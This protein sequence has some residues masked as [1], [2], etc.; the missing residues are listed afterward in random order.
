MPLSLAHAGAGRLGRSPAE[1]PQPAGAQGPDRVTHPA[2]H[3]EPAAEN[4]NSHF[5][6]F[7]Q[8]LC[9]KSIFASFLHP[10]IML[11]GPMQRS[12]L[13][14]RVSRAIRRSKALC[15]GKF[16]LCWSW[17]IPLVNNLF[18]L[19]NGN[20]YNCGLL[21]LCIISRHRKN[22]RSPDTFNGYKCVGTC[23]IHV[24]RCMYT[25]KCTHCIHCVLCTHVGHSGGVSVRTCTQPPQNET[26]SLG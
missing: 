5:R 21:T 26:L 15:R 11:L 17:L 4:S 16:W 22:P 13:L 10:V 24:G 3:P 9:V 6:N 20:S 7:L 18:R 25:Y 1:G 19:Q 23:I 12:H 8:Y 2:A 14:C